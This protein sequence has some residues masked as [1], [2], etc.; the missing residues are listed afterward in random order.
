MNKPETVSVVPQIAG[1]RQWFTLAVLMLPVLIVSIDNTILSI[2]IPAIA[3]D[4]HPSAATTLWILDIYPLVLASLLVTMGSAGDRFGRKK[5][6]LI[7]SAGFFACSILAAFSQT[8]FI[9]VCV[10]ALMGIFGAMLMPATISIIRNVFLDRN[11]RRL[12]LA[13]WAAGFAA[14]GALGPILGGVILEHYYWGGIF[15]VTALPLLVLFIL[16]PSLIPESKNP[17]PGKLDP[18]SILLSILMLG[19]FVFGVKNLATDANWPLLAVLLALSVGLGWAFVRRQLR[20]TD[21]ILDMELFANKAFS[22]AVVINLVS[23]IGFTGFVYFATQHLQLVLDYSPLESGLLMLPGLVLMIVCGLGVVRI[24]RKVPVYLVIKIA[25]GFSIA[26]YILMSVFGQSISAWQLVAAFVLL[27]IG[28][29]SAQTLTNDL[30]VSSAQ[31]DKAGAAAAVSETA[32]E[33]GAVLGNAVLGSILAFSYTR[34]LRL[35]AELGPELSSQASQ[36]LAEAITVA[37]EVE[38]ALGEQVRAAAR[39]AF[40]SGVFYTSVLAAALMTLAFILVHRIKHV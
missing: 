17:N 13:V 24:V 3:L 39:T 34:H 32:Y 29:S 38:P 26:A 37:S 35:P 22:G 11:Q 2:A 28:V 21:P 10:R 16:G 4:L 5:M 18:L 14:G 19:S 8:A 36:T 40:D 27:C 23:V 12:A 7:G 6:L 9:L 33:L 25:I 1:R 20:S 31:A 30:I 15:L